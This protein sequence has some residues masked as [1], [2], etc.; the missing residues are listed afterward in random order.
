MLLS[1]RPYFF[2]HS[3]AFDGVPVTMPASRQKRVFCSAGAIWLVARLPSPHSATPNFRPGAC[4]LPMLLSSGTAAMAA[5]CVRKRRR[6]I[7]DMADP[8][9]A[10][11][12]R[13]TEFSR[14]ATRQTYPCVY[15]MEPPAPATVLNWSA[16]NVDTRECR[17]HPIQQVAGLQRLFRV[18][19]G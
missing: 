6:S 1:G 11:Y 9:M 19:A 8:C 14:T 17:D 18:V 7:S 13:A 2:C 5:V 12:W 4:A 10:G 3:V 16:R 15:R